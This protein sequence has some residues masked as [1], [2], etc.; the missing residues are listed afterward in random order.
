MDVRIPGNAPP[1]IHYDPQPPAPRPVPLWK[2]AA[3]TLAGHLAWTLLLGLLVLFG[4]EIILA[5]LNSGDI[6]LRIRGDL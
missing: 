5:I 3:A 6:A 4:G 1:F 2:R